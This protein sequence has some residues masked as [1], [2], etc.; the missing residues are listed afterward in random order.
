[1]EQSYMREL[2]VL[3]L[4]VIEYQ[5][6]VI[7]YL[8]ILL[9]GK[10]AMPKVE[11]P[12]DKAYL[13]LTVDPLPVFG[14]PEIQ[15]IHDCG[16]LIAENNIKPIR[17]QSGKQP[18]TDTCCP[19]CGA[20]YL[21]IYNNNG[22]KGQFKRKVCKSTFFPFKPT[23]DTDPYCP[24]CG[25]KLDL[26]KKRKSFDVY[27]CPNM[28]CDYRLRKLLSMSKIQKT[29]YDKTPHLFKLRYIYRKFHIDFKPLS[30]DSPVTTP[31]GL[32][33]IKASPHVLGLVLTYHVNYALSLRKTAA[34]M[35]DV[36][37]VRVSHQ[38]IANYVNSVAPIVKPFVDHFPYQ[39]SDSFCGDETYIK[40]GGVWHYILFVFDAARQVS[41]S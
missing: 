12:I 16:T 21:Y 29:L 27:R 14:K 13:K 3:L 1:M 20:S 11:K 41:L 15:K 31:F 39:L 22:N 17:R 34:I 4:A 28:S 26:A 30:K 37:N 24:F 33:K 10:T 7:S 35:F 18:S 32:D 38:T 5:K 19:H 23:K 36:H 40:V 2:I 8:C 25:C 9:F 6:D